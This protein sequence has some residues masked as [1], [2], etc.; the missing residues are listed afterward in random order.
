MAKYEVV[1]EDGEV[2][3]VETE[4]TLPGVSF[5]KPTESRKDTSLWNEVYSAGNALTKSTG[6]LLDFAEA[7]GRNLSPFQPG[8]PR[9]FGLNENYLNKPPEPGE[10]PGAL[11]E[12]GAKAI[13]F[14]GN[15]T[16]NTLLGKVGEGIMQYAPNMA[17]P[18]GIIPA[19]TGGLASGGVR[20]AGGG[21]IAQAVAGL[22]GML[23]PSA[24][25]IFQKGYGALRDMITPAGRAQNAKYSAKEL[26]GQ[27]ADPDSALAALQK[28]KAADAAADI[29]QVGDG[30][31]LPQYQRTAEITQQPGLAGLEETLRVTDKGLR[32]VGEAA[33]KQDD[34]REA[35]RK[36]IFDR[37]NPN[38][39]LESEAGTIIRKAA[40]EGDKAADNLVKSL[41]NKA[42]SGS[43]QLPGAE[44]KRVIADTLESV[45]K[46][47]SRTVS[48]EFKKLIE[49]FQKL[50][51]EV[52]LQ[53]LNNYRTRFG[54][55]ANPGIGASDAEK[56]MSRIA[57]KIYGPL[58]DTINA[59]VE[60][61]KFPASRADAW[62]GMRAARSERGANFED[63]AMGEILEKGPFGRGY[64]VAA[65]DVT[66]KVLNTK[67]DAQQL[68]RAIKGKP[69]AIAAARSSLLSD[70]WNKST[71][72][73]TQQLNP[74][75][76]HS[77]VKLMG[78]IAPEV[79]TPPSIEAL[80]RIGADLKS[81]S[82]I[83]SLANAASKGNSVTAEKT[84]AI[85]II[86]NAVKET[87]VSAMRK[88]FRT[89]PVFGPLA[90]AGLNL[91][92][93]PAQRQALLN[94]ELAKFVLDPDYARALLSLPTKETIPIIKILSKNIA[95][96]VA[97]TGAVAEKEG[98]A[99]KKP[100][101]KYSGLLSVEEPRAKAKREPGKYDELT[102]R[103]TGR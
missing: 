63:K 93:N 13:G 82:S 14:A 10:S 68:M 24:G 3:D 5:P 45:T 88:A 43:E 29:L 46:D 81:Q 60:S 21:E 27:I 20:A 84:A 35:A 39:M 85:D 101:S 41:A 76:F 78:E 73:M 50:P 72:K 12:R 91:I 83:K 47:G 42:Y 75:T 69:E 28:A 86:Q 15:E 53:T 23:A 7:T 38:P 34:L 79:L 92:S 22:G 31:Y 48:G 77:Q 96:A 94:K 95:R 37:V 89:V 49:N 100:R 74:T 1:T 19:F 61:G 98:E 32:G 36:L 40:A 54:E 51:E 90:E 66:S 87:S 67:E 6:S 103:L 102:S 62:R 11:F 58:E 17:F 55:F 18:G 57:A 25:P 56:S 4:D 80:S 30:T 52:D 2:Y 9:V 44:A 33:T 97:A 26:I 71:N 99:Q 59:A 65:E 16:A 70:I 8:G 64:K